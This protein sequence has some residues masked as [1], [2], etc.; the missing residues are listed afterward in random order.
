MKFK[1]YSAKIVFI[2]L[3]ANVN[4][5]TNANTSANTSANASA[6]TKICENVSVYKNA[7]SKLAL[8]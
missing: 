5:G 3:D 4:V 7:S 1:T 8:S 6:N 2:Y